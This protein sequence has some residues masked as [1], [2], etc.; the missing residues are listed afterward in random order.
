MC[1]RDPFS[2]SLSLSFSSCFTNYEERKKKIQRKK[3]TPEAHQNFN[4]D[5]IGTIK[6]LDEMNPTTLGKI[7]NDDHSEPYVLLNT[8]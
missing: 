6:N 3:E 5:T 1:L 8:S 2:L 4:D 7:T